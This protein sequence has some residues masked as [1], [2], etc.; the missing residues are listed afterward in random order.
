M[1][2][3][4][5]DGWGVGVLTLLLMREPCQERFAGE[6]GS[7]EGVRSHWGVGNWTDDA[8]DGAAGAPY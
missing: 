4:L 7:G 3:S 2:I 6:G 5:T 1:E 8:D